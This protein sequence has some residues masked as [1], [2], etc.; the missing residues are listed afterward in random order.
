MTDLATLSEE[1][2]PIVGYEGAYEVSSL[3]RVRS[4][5]RTVTLR[6][7]WGWMERPIRGR[8][9]CLVAGN[10]SGRYLSVTLG[11]DDQRLVHRLV[12]EVFHGSSPSPSHEVA[13]GDG[14][15]S[16]NHADNLRWATRTENMGDC[17]ALGTIQRGERHFF[18][19]L[20]EEKVRA[21]RAA[22]NVTQEELAQQYD[23]TKSQIWCVKTRRTWAHVA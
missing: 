8:I 2:R 18:A 7:R 3:G 23:V 13:H 22:T 1:W 16:N 5:D 21:I 4:L 6:G 12:C 20:D 17:I 9:R 15:H 14:D 10:G 19:K 11:H